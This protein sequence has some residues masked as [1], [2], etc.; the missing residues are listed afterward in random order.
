MKA[1]PG[2]LRDIAEELAR[3]TG[4]RVQIIGGSLIA[5]PPPC[6]KHAGTVGRLRVRLDQRLPAGLAGYQVSS[7]GT[8]DDDEDYATPDLVVLPT[9]WGRSDEWLADPRD[10]ALAVEVAAR[11]DG[12]SGTTPGA[13]W[14]A[15]AGLAALLA[16]DPRKGTWTY[17]THPRDREYRGVL[18]GRYGEPVPL[19][20]PFTDE[21]PTVDLPLYAP[22]R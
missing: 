9:D 12:A 19:T 22:R 3:T 2:R 14:Y 18:R 15:A 1:A 6:G 16:V 5:A 4:L 11:A 21:L 7:V 10:A 8:P 17:F 20:A 13:D